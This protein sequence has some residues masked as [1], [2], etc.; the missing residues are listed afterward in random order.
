M[1]QC[2]RVPPGHS[3][4]LLAPNGLTVTATARPRAG[5]AQPPAVTVCDCGRGHH[6]SRDGRS[7]RWWGKGRLPATV[8]PRLSASLRVRIASYHRRAAAASRVHRRHRQS[9]AARHYPG[10]AVTV[11]AAGSGSGPAWQHGEADSEPQAVS[12]VCVRAVT[13]T[14]HVF[15]SDAGARI[16]ALPRPEPAAPAPGRPARRAAALR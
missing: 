7:R 12:T 4:R 11:A 1:A 5:P 16:R 3:G 10:P 8:T 9:L 2:D 6:D 14:S 13:V 15:E